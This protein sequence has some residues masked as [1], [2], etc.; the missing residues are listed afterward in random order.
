[1]IF[2][3]RS[4]SFEALQGFS[5]S[6]QL[7]S[8]KDNAM[9]GTELQAYVRAAH[10]NEKSDNKTILNGNAFQ[11]DVS[12]HKRNSLQKAGKSHGR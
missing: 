12:Y 2:V 11:N 9:K 4:T 10:T 1:M 6:S 8:T 5:V 7:G 3:Q